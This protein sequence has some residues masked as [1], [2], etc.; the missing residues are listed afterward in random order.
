MDK[1]RYCKLQGNEAIVMESTKCTNKYSYKLRINKNY[2]KNASEIK[3][4]FWKISS[5]NFKVPL[6]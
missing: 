5:R 3:F 4:G 1:Y 6:E 2:E